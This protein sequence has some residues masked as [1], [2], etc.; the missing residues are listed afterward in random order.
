M[1]NMV[2]LMAK[3]TWVSGVRTADLWAA[4]ENGLRVELILSSVFLFFVVG[5]VG[6]LDSFASSSMVYKCNTCLTK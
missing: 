1:A 3:L 2:E 4:V 5:F 6:L